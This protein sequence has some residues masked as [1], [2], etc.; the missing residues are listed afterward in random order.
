[1][2]DFLIV[3][4]DEFDGIDVERKRQAFGKEFKNVDCPSVVNVCFQCC[5]IGQ[6][7]NNDFSLTTHRLHHLE[8]LTLT[9]GVISPCSLSKVRLLMMCFIHKFVQNHYFVKLN[10]EANDIHRWIGESV[11]FHDRLI[12]LF[13]DECEDPSEGGMMNRDDIYLIFNCRN[14]SL[15]SFR[16][17]VFIYIGEYLES[18]FCEELD[19]IRRENFFPKTYA[20]TTMMGDLPQQFVMNGH[21]RQSREIVVGKESIKSMVDQ[22]NDPGMVKFDFFNTVGGMVIIRASISERRYSHRML[23]KMR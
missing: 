12:D 3:T 11:F 10:V 18:D 22:V 13:L 8:R 21:C 17:C 2:I 4:R 16:L 6:M 5:T 19:Q 20:M 1:M 15:M 14:V 23:M 7:F 9:K